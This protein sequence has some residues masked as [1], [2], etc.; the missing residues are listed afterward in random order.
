M[1]RMFRLLVPL[2]CLA[3]FAACSSALSASSSPSPAAPVSPV[4]TADESTQAAPTEAETTAPSPTTPVPTATTVPPATVSSTL[5]SGPVVKLITVVPAFGSSAPLPT[6]AFQ[7]N[8]T[9]AAPTG[10]LT[11]TLADNEKTINLRVGQLFLVELGPRFQW[12]PS[13]AD[14]AVISPVTGVTLPAG[15]QGMFAAR[16]AGKVIIQVGIEA[17]CRN[18]HPPC[19]MPEQLIRI[20]LAVQ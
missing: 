7:S 16:A 4:A 12:Q 3:L 11:I 1:S 18:A 9:P 10:A 15:A 8:P 19:M 5:A 2:A 14:L 20:T 17:P 6:T 13:A